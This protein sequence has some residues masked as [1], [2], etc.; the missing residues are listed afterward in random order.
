LSNKSH[1]AATPHRLDLELLEPLELPVQRFQIGIVG[2]GWIVRECHLPAYAETGFPVY[3]IASRTP[4]TARRAAHRFG[5]DHVPDDWRDLAADPSVEILDIAF[6]PHLQLEVVRHAVRENSQLRGILAQKPLAQDIG[7][8]REI[9][10]ICKDAGV[11]LAVNQNM[12]Y[13][14][15][16]RTLKALLDRGYLGEPVAAQITMHA[17]VVWMPYA[18]D[19]E[20]L[21]LLIMSVHHLDV[22]RFLFG[23][24]ERLLA[25]VRS[26]YE[27]ERPHLDGMAIY[28]LEYRDGLRAVSI[29]NCLTRVD[30]GIEWRVEGTAGVAKG[31][32][33][34]PDYPQGGSPSTIDFAIDLQPG[35]WFQPRWEERWF[36]DAFAGTMA[37]LMC[38]VEQGR[39]PSISGRDNLATM[40]LLEAA[41][42][43]AAE[44]VAVATADREEAPA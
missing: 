10:A 21:A 23:E 29:D 1:S 13:D 31:T 33:G 40:A 7:T 3:G 37:E 20:R 36:P 43:S 14:Q 22:F 30:Q 15:S 4:E 8:A 25:S 27:L 38:A 12:R 34:W 26:D 42:R 17:R 11:V 32:I 39:E 9:V 35:Y 6:P 41:Y 16:I 24:P 19:Y 44:G 2:A 5:I 28:V 18:G